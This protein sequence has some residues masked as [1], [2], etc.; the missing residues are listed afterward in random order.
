MAAEK[1]SSQSREAAL[2]RPFTGNCGRTRRRTVHVGCDCGHGVA[3]EVY[4][5]IDVHDA[6]AALERYYGGRL[7]RAT[8]AACGR[9]HQ[10]E[11]PVVL[12]DAKIPLLVLA[13][14]PSQRGRELELTAA[15]LLRLAE[16]TVDLPEY[17]KRPA[18]VFGIEALREVLATPPAVVRA[19]AR[20]AEER[21]LE[22]RARELERREEDVLARE[23]DLLAREENT[24]AAK[25]KL[26]EDRSA[27]ERDITELERERDAVRALSVDLAARERAFRERTKARPRPPA[28]PADVLAPPPPPPPKEADP[29]DPALRPGADVDRWRASEAASGLVA[30]DERVFLLLRPGEELAALQEQPPLLGIQ[31]Q[32]L[33][34]LPLVVIFVFP[35]AEGSEP[36]F[37]LLDMRDG[38]QRNA[39]Q[40]LGEKFDL[41]IDLYDD[42]SR[43][44][45]TWELEAPLAE[46]AAQLLKRADALL[47][48]ADDAENLDFEAAAAAYA[49]LG[50]DRL[51][52]KQHNFSDESFVDLPSPAAT[53]LALGIVSYWSEEENEEY[54]LYI[55]GFPCAHWQALRE[56]VVRRALD[57]GLRLTKDMLRFAEQAKLIE[58]PRQALRDALA[59]FAEV[60]LR[61]KAS[62]LEPAHE[63]EN[64]KLLLADCVVYGVEVESQIKDLAAACARKVRDSSVAVV[65]DESA[66]GGDLTLLGEAELL[67][68]LDD[69]AQRRDAALELCD[70]GNVDHGEAIFGALRNMTRDEVARVIPSMLQLGRGVV[71]LFVQGLGHRKSFIRQGC[72]LA[73][74]SVKAPV[75]AR[76]L[77][78]FLL[79]EPTRIWME[80]A[81]AIGDLGTPALPTV[82]DAIPAADGEGRERVAWALAH[83]ALEEEGKSAVRDA[84]GGSKLAGGKKI[85]W[86][87]L[88]MVDYVRQNDEEV[89]GQKPL[90]DHT[91]VRRFTR[92]FFESMTDDINELDDDDIVEQEEEV[93]DVDILDAAIL[94]S[95]DSLKRVPL[96]GDAVEVDDDDIID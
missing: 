46:N 76:A 52:R 45:A 20:A 22:T 70:R 5:S 21:R 77:V 50:D 2:P 24:V 94:D 1:K 16:E 43:A 64:W 91:I 74:G 38:M 82:M 30:K 66:Q 17:V 84:V 75:A 40:Q 6:P 92:R 57:Y 62:D 69:R 29:L 71:P 86:R 3:T 88:Q 81:R 11:S 31:L 73:L 14:P 56:R 61:I 49:A 15:L 41:H 53:R 18:V 25:D 63:W 72:A 55:K 68:L 9:E 36:L 26:R 58:S 48:A 78:D 79:R 80:A 59:N 33:E 37:C 96:R 19:G 13:L 28:L 39:L 47:A 89:R 65:E 93:G 27:L 60:S 12:H 95:Q 32:V 42:E 87:A 35:Q 85:A 51:G 34:G 44:V 10:L 8:C 23:E 7:H 4:E 67:P 83:I 54:L 90:S